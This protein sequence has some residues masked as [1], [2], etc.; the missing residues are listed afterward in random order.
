MQGD[1]HRLTNR[2]LFRIWSQEVVRYGDVDVQ[3]HVNNVC[4]AR[5][6]ETGRVD[7]VYNTFKEMAP[8]G[9]YFVIARLIV[10]FRR[11]ILWP[12]TVDIGTAVLALGRT[13]FTLG[14]GMFVGEDCVATAENVLVLNKNETRRSTPLPEAFRAHLQGFAAKV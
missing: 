11:E 12:S 10:D 3:G 4:F 14:Q 8:E 2:S 9:C 6:S 7:F 1:R 5:F 13:S